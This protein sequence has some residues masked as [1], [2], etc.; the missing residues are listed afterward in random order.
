ML[1]QA[2]LILT[3]IFGMILL[4]Q[5]L[6]KLQWGHLIM[7]TSGIVLVQ[8]GSIT[9]LA[10]PSSS[11]VDHSFFLGITMMFIAGFC[12]AFSGVYI[13][14]CFKTNSNFLVRNAQMAVYSCIFAILGIFIKTD[15][16]FKSFFRGYDT[17]VVFLVVL[18][19]IG[20]FLVSW[21][22]RIT[23]TVAKN[24]AQG[25]GF[26][27]ASAIAIFSVS[28]RLRYSVGVILVLW[29]VFGSLLSSNQKILNEEP[30][31]I[32]KEESMV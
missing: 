8:L 12:V 4:K 13:E 11:T 2:K 10:N 23:S 3:P 27:T 25:L 22:V 7:M 32:D 16:T 17:R 31:K 20:G 15:I 26:L 21:C 29:G 9:E 6:S 30:G 18:Q 5:S 24:Y 19:A 28:R 1:S 14:L